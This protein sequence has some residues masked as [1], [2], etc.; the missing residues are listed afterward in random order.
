MA[1]I[2]DV[3]RAIVTSDWH[4]PTYSKTHVAALFEFA[5]DFKPHTSII[6]GDFLDLPELSRHTAG[7]VA[8]LEGRR[9]ASS[10]E[11]GRNVIERY[12][13]ALGKQCTERVFMWGNHCNRVN[14][15]LQKGDNAVFVG[16]P[17]LDIGQRLE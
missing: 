15:W 5:R 7:S 1:A 10:F 16:D 4:V 2:H 11:S 6:A 17:L 8:Q 9:V 12:G 13:R 3:K 14:K